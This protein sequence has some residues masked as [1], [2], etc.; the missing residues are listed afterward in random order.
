MD[1]NFDD[2]ALKLFKR[3]NLSAQGQAPS[4]GQSSRYNSLDAIYQSVDCR[5]EVEVLE[6]LRLE[7]ELV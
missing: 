7:I 2:E 4:S 3:L 6:E 5:P 1:L